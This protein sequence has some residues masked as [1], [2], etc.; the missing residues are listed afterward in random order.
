[1]A[2]RLINSITLKHN[3]KE[4]EGYVSD[5]GLECIFGYDD[6]YDSP[7]DSPYKYIDYG[8]DFDNL[9]EGEFIVN[10]K[11]GINIYGNMESYG[12]EWNLPIELHDEDETIEDIT[13]ILNEGELKTRS[14]FKKI[15][16][17][18]DKKHYII[19]DNPQKSNEHDYD[20]VYGDEETKW[21]DDDNKEFKAYFK[22]DEYCTA[23]AHDFDEY[24]TIYVNKMGALENQLNAELDKEDPKE[25]II[26]KLEERIDDL[27]NEHSNTLDMISDG[28]VA[29]T[30]TPQD[31]AN[32]SS[33]VKMDSFPEAA[34]SDDKQYWT[35]EVEF[36]NGTTEEFSVE[37]D[38]LLPDDY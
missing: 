28:K 18:L 7:E 15:D 14:L 31:E 9:Q 30:I 36:E 5:T 33:A 1:M 12:T 32:I 37:L 4:Y 19:T 34:V 29:C 21:F 23:G 26:N 24:G 25:D 20:N 17:R 6:D 10:L 13:I 3:G 16:V 2:N 38:V 35:F 11:G 27:I 22:P 8:T